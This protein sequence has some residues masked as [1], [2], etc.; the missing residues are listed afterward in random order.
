[1]EEA[2][3]ENSPAKNTKKPINRVQLNEATLLQPNKGLKR[4]YQI[5]QNFRPSGNSKSDLRGLLTLFQEWHFLVAPKFEFNYFVQKC[6]V[7]GAKAPIRGYMNRLREYHSGKLTEQEF[8]NPL[9]ELNEPNVEYEEDRVYVS[10]EKLFN[11]EENESFNNNR[12]EV[13]E[14][15][16][17]LNDYFEYIEDEEEEGEGEGGQQEMNEDE[18][19]YLRELAMEG[20]GKRSSEKEDEGYKRIKED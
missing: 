2:I 9:S 10:P 3:V 18:L 17:K 20:G 12:E 13:L 5:T 19:E 7:L 16:P 8:D 4:L 1:M 6:Q 15:V 14:S 11:R